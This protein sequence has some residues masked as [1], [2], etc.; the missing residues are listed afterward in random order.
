[1][2][3]A[4]DVAR[5]MRPVVC[6]AVALASSLAC[7]LLSLAAST[8]PMTGMSEMADASTAAAAGTVR[9]A[10]AGG[11]T[12][13]DL[14]DDAIGDVNRGLAS[15]V[16]SVPAPPMSSMCHHG[17]VTDVS[18]FNTTAAGV[19]VTGLLALLMAGRRDTFVVLRARPRIRAVPRRRRTPRT[20]LSPI[21]LCVLRV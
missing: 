17:C 3:L 15:S 8:G 20:L 18:R 9:S 1:M 19:A 21:S 10:A 12:L 13:R 6:V 11:A 2:P 5:W 14:T 4:P 7:I 16:A